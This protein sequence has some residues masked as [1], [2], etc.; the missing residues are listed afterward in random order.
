[1]A[2]EMKNERSVPRNLSI[3]SCPC[4]PRVTNVLAKTATLWAQKMYN[5]VQSEFQ[6]FRDIEE[7]NSTLGQHP[8]PAFIAYIKGEIQ[9]PAPH[10]QQTATEKAESH[11]LKKTTRER[12]NN[13]AR[14]VNKHTP[15]CQQRSEVTGRPNLRMKPPS[16]FRRKRSYIST[17]K[18]SPG[19]TE[20]PRRKSSGKRNFAGEHQSRVD[21]HENYS[22]ESATRDSVNKHIRAEEVTNH[23]RFPGILLVVAVLNALVRVVEKFCAYVQREWTEFNHIYGHESEDVQYTEPA[24]IAYLKGEGTAPYIS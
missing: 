24:F 12:I 5:Y 20:S 23:L 13:K 8:D 22:Q 18:V 14:K 15:T 16:V 9:D 19:S 6:E 4:I 2:S 11:R 10:C 1:M 3:V 21:C 17:E 7:D